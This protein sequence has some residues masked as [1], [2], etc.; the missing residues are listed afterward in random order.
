[1]V[2]D[3]AAPTSAPSITITQPNVK[4]EEPSVESA[5]NAQALDSLMQ[6]EAS[7]TFALSDTLPVYRATATL[8]NDI[9]HTKLDVRFDWAK[10]HVIG[11][12]WITA[13]PYFYPQNKVVFDG[14]G[15]EIKK[16]TMDGSTAPLVYDYKDDK[17]SINL[18]KTYTRTEKYTVYIEYVAKPNEA[19]EGGSAAITSDKGLFFINPEGTEIDK[20]QQIWT[21]GETESN[22]RWFPTFDKPNEKN[23]Q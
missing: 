15:F 6:A 22:S 18:G 5:T 17:L 2:T 9:I 19:P 14:K 8:E 20:P 16:V 3:K 10:Q 4:I 11:K 1:M 21:Q 23:D 12:A 13:K 7:A